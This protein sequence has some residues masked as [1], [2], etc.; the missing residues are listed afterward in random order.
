MKTPL[1]TLILIA[2][3]MPILAGCNPAAPTSSPTAQP[4]VETSAIASEATEAVEED[5]GTTIDATEAALL[6]EPESVGFSLDAAQLTAPEDVLAELVTTGG[7]GSGGCDAT[8]ERSLFA[9]APNEPAVELM[10]VLDILG[11]NWQP[12]DVVIVTATLPDGQTL[13]FQA[14]VEPDGTFNLPFQTALQDAPGEYTFVAKGSAG[15]TASTSI[16]VSAPDGPRMRSYGDRLFL[17]GFGPGERVRLIVYRFAEAKNAYAFAGWQ[18]FNVDANGR[19]F[20]DLDDS[21]QGPLFA[22]GILGDVSGP[23][24]EFAVIGAIE[25][26]VP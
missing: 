6:A 16:E 14:D 5:G 23:V 24:T 18:A 12:G 1:I 19:L 10:A 13:D 3:M 17:Y 8:R 22:F 25:K 2:L 15:A 11:C 9:E 4:T 7:G 21:A 26:L 20:I